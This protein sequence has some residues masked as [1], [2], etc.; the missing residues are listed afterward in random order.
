MST[1]ETIQHVRDIDPDYPA[2]TVLLKGRITSDLI[3]VNKAVADLREQVW[4]T[5]PLQDENSAW[6]PLSAKKGAPRTVLT[7]SIRMWGKHTNP[8][9]NLSKN[10]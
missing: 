9:V 5:A 1:I 4:V 7:V 3:N 6:Y 8:D 10:Q 2:C